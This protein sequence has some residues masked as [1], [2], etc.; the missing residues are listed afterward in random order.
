MAPSGQFWM[1]CS[2]IRAIREIRGSFS[3]AVRLKTNMPKW[4]SFSNLWG[5]SPRQRRAVAL[6]SVFVVSGVWAGY[7]SMMP[8]NLWE[9][10]MHWIFCPLIFVFVPLFVL[11]AVHFSISGA[12]QTVLRRPAWD[13]FSLIWW[14]DPLQCLLLMTAGYGAMVAGSGLRLFGTS[15]AG[16]WTF[17]S[18]LSVFCGLLIGQYFVY[19]VYRAR[20]GVA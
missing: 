18:D 1:F 13:R 17:L 7:R 9:A 8:E 12:K 14:R 19:R 4:R 6:N 3:P 5:E 15:A 10:D 11:G 16:V 20:I 2:S